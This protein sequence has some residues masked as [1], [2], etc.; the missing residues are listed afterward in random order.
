MSAKRPLQQLAELGQSVWIDFLSRELLASGELA[1]LVREDAVVGVTS[2]PAIFEKAITHS[3]AY[4]RQLRDLL[5]R[6]LSARE[7]FGE[8]ARVDVTAAC[9]L[10]RPVWEQT[11][12]RDGY[13]S[14]EVDPD[15]ADDAMAQYDEAR[16]L[17]ESIA[18]PNV[19]VKIPAT[20][21]G[22]TAIEDSIA[23]GRSINV[24]L[25]FSV[26]RYVA[27]AHAYRDGLR[28]FRA[29]GGDVSTIRSVASFF[30]SRIDS[31]TDRR[32]DE[33]SAPHALRGKLGIANA[34]LAYERYRQ[35]FSPADELWAELTA[36]GAHPQ[37]PLW[38]STSTKNPSYRDVLYVEELIGPETVNTMPEETLLAFQ[39]HGRVAPT[40]QRGVDEAHRLL[41]TLAAAG[42]DYD[43]VVETLEAEAIEKFSGSLSRVVAGLEARRHELA[44]SGGR[45]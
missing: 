31:E 36:A 44:P 22:V 19:L 13:V 1:R 41:E 6:R 2:N 34:R 12:G 7:I 35:L 43:D 20:K 29:D 40:I 24:T 4:D 18:R 14:I 27:V 8:L 15:L 25:I 11:G 3:D 28:R 30:V 9:D 17:H 23:A 38:A 5:P 45:G 10:L 21:A 32:L 39:D 26:E 42:I 37:R 16:Q 33:R